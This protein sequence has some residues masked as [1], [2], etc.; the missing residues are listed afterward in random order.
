MAY[1][2]ITDIVR[3]IDTIDFLV[4]NCGKRDDDDNQKEE[5]EIHV[6][7]MYASD[8]SISCGLN[9]KSSYE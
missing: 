7:A 6:F 2:K 8:Y 3:G 5:E 1:K 9:D 4:V